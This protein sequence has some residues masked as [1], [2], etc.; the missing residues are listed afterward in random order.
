MPRA[1]NFAPL[2]TIRNLHAKQLRELRKKGA[3]AAQI[4][5]TRKALAQQRA[6]LELA[7]R[8]ISK[9]KLLA[10]QAKKKSP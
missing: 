1:R 3:S 7:D 5:E 2:Q 6:G 8:A 4:R 10:E 9:S